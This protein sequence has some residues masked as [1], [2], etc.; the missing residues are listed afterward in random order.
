[1]RAIPECGVPSYTAAINVCLMNPRSKGRVTVVRLRNN[2]DDNDEEDVRKREGQSSDPCA[3]P[4]RECHVRSTPTR[5]SNCRVMIDP[6]YLTDP[7]DVDAL[8]AGFGA[9]SKIKRHWFGG[10]TEILPGRHLAIVFALVSFASSL[11][12]WLMSHF[13]HA[14]LVEGKRN[15]IRILNRPRWF[16]VYVAEF[17]NPFYHWC[18]TCA[19]GEDVMEGSDGAMGE[20]GSKTTCRDGASLLVVDKR[21]CVRGNKGLRICDASVFPA[22]ISAPTVLTCAALGYAASAFI[23]DSDREI[24]QANNS[25]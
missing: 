16:S 1:M 10:C 13:W 24:G 8:W 20:H 5:L 17:A 23:L 2:D 9:S 6:G 15:S 25:D 21:L 11:I 12:G 4:R 18:G 14:A 22:C 19:M 7:W 3:V